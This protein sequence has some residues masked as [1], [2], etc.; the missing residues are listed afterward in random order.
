MRKISILLIALSV[1]SFACSSQKAATKPSNNIIFDAE[2][3][4]KQTNEKIEK[5]YYE[6]A[7]QALEDIKTKDT[8]G[9]YAALSQIRIGDSYFEEGL[10]EEA[11]VEYSRFLE[12][13][14]Y[15]KYAYYAQYQLAMSHFKQIKTP[16]ISYGVAMKALEEFEKLQVRYPRNPYMDVTES[17][18][19]MCR[20]VLAEYE[21]YVGQFYFNKG[22]YTPAIQRFNALIEKYPNSKKE[23]DALFH[24]GLSYKNIGNKEKALEIL[25]MLI[26]KYPATKE[27][28]EARKLAA[29]LGNEKGK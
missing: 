26:E 15:H 25:N 22:S 17:R 29:S 10:Y 16:D 21:F 19:K 23:S 28:N 3:A 5:G 13:H 20:N 27:A 9:K 1:I 2:A 14:P 18:I 24:L 11:A 12:I 7:R 8:S 4:L 6:E